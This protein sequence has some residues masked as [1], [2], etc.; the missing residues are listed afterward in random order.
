MPCES[1]RKRGQLKEHIN[2]FCYA[3]RG[4]RMSKNNTV[5]VPQLAWSGEC[6]YHFRRPVPWASEIV[7]YI[8]EELLGVD[9]I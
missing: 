9:N 8:L 4:R 5:M 3:D 6:G 1:A 7:P 2:S